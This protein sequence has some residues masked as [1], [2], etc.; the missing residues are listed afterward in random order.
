MKKS[1]KRAPRG[2]AKRN[3]FSELREG[4]VAL[5]EARQ[6]CPAVV[7]QGLY[8]SRDFDGLESMVREFLARPEAAAGAGRISV[9]IGRSNRS[10][11]RSF[12]AF[13][14]ANCSSVV[15]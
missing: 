15:V 14:A 6:P 10:C 2:A 12:E 4:F 3:L 8:A 13:A 5:A 11:A 7:A 1:T 9:A